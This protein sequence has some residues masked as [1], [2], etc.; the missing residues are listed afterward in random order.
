MPI[1]RGNRG[2]APDGFQEGAALK[3][4]K[5]SGGWLGALASALLLALLLGYWAYKFNTY[6][7]PSR[8][9]RIGFWEGPP[10][11]VE[12][13]DGSAGGLGPEV[14]NEAARRAGIRLEWVKP[15]QGPEKLL[16]GGQLDLWGVMS[17]T[18]RRRSL[19]FLTS[20]WAENYYG[21][22]SLAAQSPVAETVIGSIDSPIWLLLIRRVRP[23]AAIKT[24]PGRS[25]LFD[26]MCRGE[27]PQVLMDQRSLMTHSMLRTPACHGA[28][29]AV[30]ALPD[31]RMD[32]GTGAAPGQEIHAQ[33]I[34]REIDRMAIDGTLNR[35][36]A[37]YAI[38]LG[39]LDW[40]PKLAAS[41][42]RQQALQ[43]GILLALLIA[44]STAW[45]VRRVRAARQQTQIALNEAQRANAAKSEFLATMSHEIR[46]P[47]NGI[48]GMTDLLLET[49][50][51]QQQREYGDSIRESAG[52]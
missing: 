45:Q 18:P 7:P 44:A 39:S 28:S 5:I 10:F 4:P 30:T 9:L 42:R 50:L 34:R 33:A 26:A 27:I 20:P 23:N 19:F 36:S 12:N 48:I 16:P 38:G 1:Y 40:V 51:D 35:I 13:K 14:I 3:V 21:L 17:I 6:S 22:V 43:G 31:V 24:Y 32:Q 41:E 15:E 47:M 8:P 2:S 29:F 49:P 37:P 11:E 46:T 25:Q 52:S